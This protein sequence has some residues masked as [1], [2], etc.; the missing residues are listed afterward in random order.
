MEPDQFIDTIPDTPQAVHLIARSDEVES[1]WVANDPFTTHLNIV[2]Y[3]SM[4]RGSGTFTQADDVLA[5]R[6]MAIFPTVISFK[7]VAN[8]ASDSATDNV[9]IGDVIMSLPYNEYTK[10]E[11]NAHFGVDE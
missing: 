3:C 10:R 7:K 11:I 6:I 2:L 9:D 8:L 5:D 1:L 4:L